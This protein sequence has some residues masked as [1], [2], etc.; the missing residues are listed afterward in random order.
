MQEILKIEQQPLKLALPT[1]EK[2]FR[3]QYTTEDGNEWESFVNYKK[4]IKEMLIVPEEQGFKPHIYNK[5]GKV[6]SFPS[7]ELIVSFFQQSPS[8]FCT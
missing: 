7:S 8:H 1:F 2:N 6:V 3:I 5:S 4:G